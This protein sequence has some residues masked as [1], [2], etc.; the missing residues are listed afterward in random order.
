MSVL[1]ASEET[2]SE[3]VETGV[4]LVDFWANWC[5]PCKMIAPILD[6]LATEYNGKVKVVKVDIERARD[7]INALGIMS[8]PT[9]YLYVDG[10][11]KEE[12]VGF[13]TKES[14][15]SLVKKYL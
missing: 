6:E 4:V 15:M 7:L 13:Q 9:L 11:K 12:T 3:E 2:F 5:G 14:L 1:H 8:I 10:E